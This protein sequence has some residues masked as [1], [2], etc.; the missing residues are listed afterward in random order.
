M[1]ST[2]VRA[3][4]LLIVGE[5]L[6]DAAGELD[7]LDVLHAQIRTETLGLVAHVI[8]Q[9]RAHDGRREAR[10]V[11]D[12]GGLHQQ[13]AEIHPLEDQRLE[14]GACGVDGGGVTGGAGAD[15]DDV[16]DSGGGIAHADDSSHVVQPPKHLVV[17]T[18]PGSRE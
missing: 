13:T 2:T 17:S 3:W 16:V 18:S 14:F 10:E 1:A 15:D 12:F 4:K 5:D 9:R 7:P 8:H 11:L 6:L